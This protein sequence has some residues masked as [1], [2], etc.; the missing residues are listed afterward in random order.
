MWVSVPFVTLTASKALPIFLHGGSTNAF[1][2]SE[3]TNY[4]FDVNTGCFE[5]A[6]DRFAQFFIKPLMSADATMREIKA[7]DFG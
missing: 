7:V 1:T 3:M 4:F 5:E 6:L 2:A